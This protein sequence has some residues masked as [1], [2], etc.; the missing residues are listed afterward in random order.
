MQGKYQTKG[1]QSRSHTYLKQPQSPTH[2]P[3]YSPNNSFNHQFATKP[4]GS[5][6]AITMDKKSSTSSPTS[7]NMTGINPNSVRKGFI[8]KVLVILMIQ[9]AISTLAIGTTFIDQS[10]ARD[11]ITKNKWLIWVSLITSILIMGFL[12]CKRD[13]SKKVPLNYILLLTYTCCMSYLLASIAAVTKSEVVLFALGFTVGVVFLVSLYA[14][15]AK[16]DLSRKGYIVSGL[17]S[18]AI[19]LLI[20]GLCF[21]SRILNILYSGIVGVAFTILLAINIQRLTGKYETRYSLDEY[22][23]AALDLYIDI[24]QIFLVVLSVRKNGSE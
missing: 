14:C 13:V 4:T 23:I 8:R 22:I 11:F 10:G 17:L 1:Q 12:I 9:L 24:V 18:V 5:H 6:F 16:T 19:M 2:S 21:R 15:F 3:T 20:F 7:Y